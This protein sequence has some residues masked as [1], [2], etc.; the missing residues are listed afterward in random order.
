M[1]RLPHSFVTTKLPGYF[2]HTEKK[3][4]FSIKI[5]GELRQL[6]RVF[7]V[8]WNQFFDGYIVSHKGKPRRLSLD[9]LNGLKYDPNF[10]HIIPYG[11][12]K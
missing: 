11:E 8:Y 1:I 3:Q 5:G 6:K 12:L 9:Y 2:W 10:T 7:P 4:L